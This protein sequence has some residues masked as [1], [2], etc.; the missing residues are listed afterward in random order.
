MV[1]LSFHEGHNLFPAFLSAIACYIL[2]NTFHLEKLKIWLLLK[3]NIPWATSESDHVFMYLLDVRIWNCAQHQV[4]C[5]FSIH[6]LS[7]F[8]RVLELCLSIIKFPP[9]TLFVYWLSLCFHLSYKMFWISIR[10]RRVFQHAITSG[11]SCRIFI[12]LLLKFM[13]QF[14]FET[15]VTMLDKKGVQFYFFPY[16]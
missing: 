9:N 8:L 7:A 4:L 12:V 16:K 2:F 3:I 6:G 10:S 13:S 1:S 5:P 15:N 11:V 14:F